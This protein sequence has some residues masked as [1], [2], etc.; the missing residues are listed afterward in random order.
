MRAATLL[1]VPRSEIRRMT[2]EET[3]MFVSMATSPDFV[4]TPDEIMVRL[5]EEAMGVFQVAVMMK[6]LAVAQPVQR[7]STNTILFLISLC[8]RVG[9]VVQWAYFLFEETR[10][11][12]SVI[13]MTY[14]AMMMFP[15][16]VPTEKGYHDNW[17]A[18]KYLEEAKDN[19]LDT[20]LAF[21][22]SEEDGV[23]VA[24]LTDPE[25]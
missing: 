23:I 7:Y 21:R 14:F 15:E 13:D 16:G 4:G 22:P 17:D 8:D 6:R 10:T 18:Q 1:S 24:L 12:G 9:Y 20:E 5:G 19:W 25:A 3:G 11:R 2:K